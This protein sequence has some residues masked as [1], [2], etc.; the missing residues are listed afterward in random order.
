MSA[1]RSEPTT[2]QV[3]AAERARQLSDLIAAHCEHGEQHAR[4]APEVVEACRAAGL[5]ALTVPEEVG[6]LEAPLVDAVR[7]LDI[8]ASVDPAVAWYMMNSVPLGRMVAR[9]DRRHWKTVLAQPLG[10]FGYSVVPGQARAVD[11]GYLLSGDWPL[12]TGVD[13]ADWCVVF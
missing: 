7:A 12:M 4:L 2:K 10:N 9:V 3:G 1:L 6:G 5:F 11:D 13:D 8:V